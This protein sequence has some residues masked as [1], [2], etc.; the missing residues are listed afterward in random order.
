VDSIQISTYMAVGSICMGRVLECSVAGPH[1]AMLGDKQHLTAT[2]ALDGTG[3]PR[4]APSQ[5]GSG[6]PR[7][8]P[9]NSAPPRR[10]R[11]GR[12]IQLGRDP[13]RRRVQLIAAGSPLAVV[14]IAAVALLVTTSRSAVQH[15]V[16]RVLF[17]HWHNPHAVVSGI[18]RHMA[19]ASEPAEALQRLV[20]LLRGVLRLPYVAF[21]TADDTLV[22]HSG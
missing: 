14:L 17:G 16:D 13:T 18:G 8:G 22:A 1:V 2:D 12:G 15:V 4:S 6:T 7:V 11:R 3:W 19:A 5:R 9:S 21:H 10:W 20:D